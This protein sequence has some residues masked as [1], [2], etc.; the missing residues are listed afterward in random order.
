[1]EPNEDLI[2]HD[3]IV[4]P[5]NFRYIFNP[6]HHVCGPDQGQNVK[7]LIYVHTSTFNFARRMAIRETWAKRS[8][9]RDT[10]LVFMMGITPE[11]RTNT[12]LKLEFNYYNDIVQEDFYDSYKNL[13]YKGIFNL[14][15][16]NKL[17]KTLFNY[18][19]LLGIMALKWISNYCNNAQYIFKTDDDIIINTFKMLRHVNSLGDPSNHPKNI[20][21]KYYP[22]NAIT[23][24]RNPY[25]KWY[26]TPKEYKFAYFGAYCSGSA[27]LLT[28]GM[29]SLMFN[30]SQYIEFF[31][32]DDYYLTGLLVRG[33]NGIYNNMRSIYII[34]GNLVEAHF[35]QQEPI[36]IIAHISKSNT[37]NKMHNLWINVMKSELNNHP[38]MSTPPFK[39][40][41]KGD[42]GVFEFKWGI[43]MW[44]AFVK[45]YVPKM[46]STLP[47]YDY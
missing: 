1:M 42:F 47:E 41:E 44:K 33:I 25:N 9:F 36:K 35:N 17:I 22:N 20:F 13:T 7:L 39:L 3:K 40:V 29:A 19:F 18:F 34:P 4:N 27:F 31:W 5:H 37:V 26:L 32:V 46:N 21:C 38:E 43:E 2:I 14:L 30:I 12:R 24:Q 15:K 10:R 16:K 8:M 6:G 23:V 45:N 11:T 28:K